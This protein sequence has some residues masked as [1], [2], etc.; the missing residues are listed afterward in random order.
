MPMSRT[1]RGEW[2]LLLLSRVKGTPKDQLECRGPLV[3]PNDTRLLSPPHVP[4]I[5]L[6][7]KKV[8]IKPQECT[9][10]PLKTEASLEIVY[11]FKPNWNQVKLDQ[12]L[13]SLPTTQQVGMYGSSELF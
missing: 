8:S 2:D 10:S 13:K 9:V 1:P 5:M 6:E 7:K 3:P 4:D 11:C 12:K